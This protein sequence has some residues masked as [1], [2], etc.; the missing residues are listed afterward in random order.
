MWVGVGS[1]WSPLTVATLR[2]TVPLAAVAGTVA[3]MVTV[4]EAPAG[5]LGAVHTIAPGPPGAGVVQV[6]GAIAVAL[7]NATP[8]GNSSR[9]SNPV[10]VPGP[11][12]VATSVQVCSAPCA[13]TSAETVLITP[14][15][16]YGL[17]GTVTPAVAQPRNAVVG[18][19][20]V[21]AR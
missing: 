3:V 14:R 16:T 15:S 5:T 8:E 9:T 19:S 20:S 17:G 11:W 2:N 12:L 13:T 21:F 1:G 10:D 18:W 4:S 6:S 7:T